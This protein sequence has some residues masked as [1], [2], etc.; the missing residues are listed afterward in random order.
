MEAVPIHSIPSKLSVTLG[1]GTGPAQMSSYVCVRVC[2]WD[3]AGGDRGY[4]LACDLSQEPTFR[5]CLICPLL[6]TS[7]WF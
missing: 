4:S 6:S 3:D 5:F 7:A 2:A 1:S